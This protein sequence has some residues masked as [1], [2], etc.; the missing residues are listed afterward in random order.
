MKFVSIFVFVITVF[1]Y[2]NCGKNFEVT[3]DFVGQIN[4]SEN[5]DKEIDVT[6]SLTGIKLENCDE[7][8]GFLDETSLASSC[9][10]VLFG[11]TDN[12]QNPLGGPTIMSFDNL[13]N[14]EPQYSLYVY[15]AKKRRWVYIPAGKQID[16][17][18]KQNWVYPVGTVFWK[19]F[20]ISKDLASP[21]DLV[22]IELRRIVK[23]SDDS[24]PADNWHFSTFVNSDVTAGSLSTAT[25]NSN[26]DFSDM[27]KVD[28]GLSI[29]QTG[30]SDL[31]YAVPQTAFTVVAGDD[32]IDCHNSGQDSA[33]LGFNN[34]QLSTE[35]VHNWSYVNSKDM[36]N[37]T[38]EKDS[39]FNFS[40]ISKKAIGFIN[41]NCSSC[42]SPGGSAPSDYGNFKHLGYEGL[43]DLSEHNIYKM[44]IDAGDGTSAPASGICNLIPNATTGAISIF[45]GMNRVGTLGSPFPMP[46]VIYTS[47]HQDLEGRKILGEW[48]IELHNTGAIDLTTG[49]SQKAYCKYNSTGDF[50]DPAIL[51]IS[52]IP[53][54]ICP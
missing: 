31:V 33:V 6:I 37:T 20:S 53:A 8:D 2:Q 23:I 5:G 18:N 49:S 28:N 3:D 36:A 17:R 51:S 13:F 14:F 38:L 4:G 9:L 40:E 26:P 30:G 12:T 16:T 10:T 25:V 35:D 22:L 1:G 27:I 43:T 45:E 29:N 7:A 19:E 52:P 44:F 11:Q 39:S 48:A 46:R 42:H 24:S 21:N 15:G 32:C 54:I 34:Y 47:R 41:T 50:L